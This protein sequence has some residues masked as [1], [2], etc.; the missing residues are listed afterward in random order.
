MF[1]GMAGLSE[2]AGQRS[3]GR[4]AIMQNFP[5][6]GVNLAL[7]F[8]TLLLPRASRPGRFSNSDTPG[9]AIQAPP[10]AKRFRS[11]YR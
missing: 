9:F 1:A 2:E 8:G 5:V 6:K 7:H 4:E 3:D 11:M 10:E